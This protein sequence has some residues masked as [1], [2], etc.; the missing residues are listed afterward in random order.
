[1]NG[2]AFRRS[3]QT[4]DQR[5]A[6]RQALASAG[7]SPP[8]SI[9]ADGQL[10]RF[11]SNGK[12]GDDAGWY[13]LHLDGVADGVAAG[14]FGC[15]R[16]GLSRSWRANLGR[17]LSPSEE[18][19]H[20]ARVAAVR[21][22]REAE[23]AKR[24]AAARET[25]AAIWVAAKPAPADHP[26]LM[27]KSIGPHRLRVHDDRLIVPMY[28]GGELHSLQF[29]DADGEKRFL[30]GGRASGC[31]FGIGKPSGV[32]HVCEG[33]ATGASVHEAT[34]GAVAIAFTAGNLLA[35]AT[36]LRAKYPDL[37]QILCADDD[38]GTPGNPG[39]TKAREAASAIG[40]LVALPDFG[41]SRPDNATDFND[42]HRHAGLGA[43]RAAVASGVP[44]NSRWLD[45][46]AEDAN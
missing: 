34:S 21:Q 2:N 40:G 33:F 11:A 15:W 13:C 16:T 45:A 30:P 12:R 41:D 20:Q 43:V 4:G 5:A 39:L 26:Y 6:F 24:K 14:A 35:V 46:L 17:Q 3:L 18:D 44:A 19:A 38:A 22:Q 9:Q 31:Y 42:L 27:A 23:D 36:A 37:Q 1:M 32:M 8:D 7:L 25:A 28:S 29:I 10:H